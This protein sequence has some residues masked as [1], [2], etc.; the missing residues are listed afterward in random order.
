M[1]RAEILLPQGL[2]TAERCSISRRVNR[3]SIAAEIGKLATGKWIGSLGG[4]GGCVPSLE[5]RELPLR[6]MALDVRSGYLWRGARRECSGALRGSERIVGAALHVV[7][8]GQQAPIV[9][10]LRD[11]IYRF[12]F[13]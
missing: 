13:K 5:N 4:A 8:P 12:F 9:R 2:A 7:E 10:I 3:A 6:Q 11:Q 1:W